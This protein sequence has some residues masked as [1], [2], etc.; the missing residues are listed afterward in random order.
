[1]FFLDI[2]ST[3]ICGSPSGWHDLHR[4]R[5]PISGSDR[6]KRFHDM[7]TFVALLHFLTTHLEVWGR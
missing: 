3:G 7:V 1:M 2:R 6:A 4:E 5:L